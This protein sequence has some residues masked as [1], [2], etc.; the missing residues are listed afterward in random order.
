MNRYTYT[1]SSPTLV[2]S[3][4][5]SFNA[6]ET[7]TAFYNWSLEAA[8]H[9]PEIQNPYPEEKDLR[10]HPDILLRRVL[11]WYFKKS[12]SAYRFEKIDNSPPLPD[13]N[14]NIPIEGLEGLLFWC[15]NVMVETGELGNT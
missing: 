13:F 11:Y 4:F 7:E 6:E 9:I 5:P 2:E 14:S 1:P 15:I 12:D 8:R 10:I 3:G